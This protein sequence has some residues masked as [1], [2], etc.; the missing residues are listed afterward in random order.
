MKMKRKRKP[1][2]LPSQ[3]NGIVPELL[4]PIRWRRKPNTG[5]HF[6]GGYQPVKPG[7]TVTATLKEI[8]PFID[9][10]E[11][12]EPIPTGAPEE[13]VEPE[14]VPV[15]VHKGGGR[16]DVI[17]SATK[18]RYNDALLN[19]EEALAFIQTGTEEQEL[20]E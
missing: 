13:A 17:N 16:Y 7:D 18:K 20:E 14:G 6:R 1:T 3:D 9:C 11:A 8:R 5:V 4:Q 2:L 12:L 19:K 15:L 10:Y